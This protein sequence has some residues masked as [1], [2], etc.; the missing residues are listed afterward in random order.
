MKLTKQ[1]SQ[2][3]ER[4]ALKYELY[5]DTLTSAV[6]AAI[7]QAESKGY[8]L[9]DD[10]TFTQIGAGPAKPS[11]GKTN[12]YSLKLFKGDK[13]VKEHLH[14]QVYNRGTDRNTFELNA[15]IS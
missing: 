6:N 13:Q 10:D 12:R 8:S 11:K 15:Y 2:L 5:H 7:S 9:D 4:R 3:L 14:I 1:L